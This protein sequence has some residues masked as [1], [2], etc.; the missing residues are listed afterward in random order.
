MLSST[1]QAQVEGPV[2]H[3]DIVH[4]WVLSCHR[5][6]EGDPKCLLTAVYEGDVTDEDPIANLYIG[7]KARLPVRQNISGTLS[8]TLSVTVEL[9]QTH[10][11]CEDILGPRA[12]RAHA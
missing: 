11:R 10:I 1:Q 4:D 9:L 3:R 5:K 2:V 7:H 12:L 6:L 8:S